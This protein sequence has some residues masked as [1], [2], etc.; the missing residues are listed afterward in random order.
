M[1]CGSI[2]CY[3]ST[4]RTEYCH[5]SPQ[6]RST[7]NMSIHHHSIHP[8]QNAKVAPLIQYVSHNDHDIMSC[9]IYER[10][11]PSLVVY[12]YWIP[13]PNQQQQISP[14]AKQIKRQRALTPKQDNTSTA[15]TH[16]W[17]LKLQS[18]T[19]SSLSCR[20]LNHGTLQPLN[21]CLTTCCSFPTSSPF[22][23]QIV[24]EHLSA[25]SAIIYKW[26]TTVHFTSLF[27]VELVDS[28]LKGDRSL[29]WK[30]LTLFCKKTVEI[31]H[32]GKLNVN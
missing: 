27:T 15:K 20:T 24:F 32:D 5:P 16:N 9:T 3:S 19:L 25:Q 10:D 14:T 30:H 29:V 1:A 8:T 11:E 18:A 26:R 12:V 28:V 17:I 4:W 31:E 23:N 22:F 2:S 6:D 13:N 21:E 7:N